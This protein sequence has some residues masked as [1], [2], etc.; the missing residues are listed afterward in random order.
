[1]VKWT[2][3]D[4]VEQHVKEIKENMTKQFDSLLKEVNG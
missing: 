3:E 4:E 1:M 2:K